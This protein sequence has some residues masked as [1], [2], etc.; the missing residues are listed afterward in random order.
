MRGIGTKLSCLAALAIAQPAAAATELFSETFETAANGG[1]GKFVS[2][3]QVG[4]ASGQAYRDIGFGGVDPARLANR[5]AAFGG[6]NSRFPGTILSTT[7]AGSA[8]ATL[9]TINFDAGYIGGVAANIAGQY[10]MFTAIDGD[11]NSVEADLQP[12]ASGDPSATGRLGG[13]DNVDTVFSRYQ[14][15]FTGR[16]PISLSFTAGGERGDNADVLLDNVLVRAGAVPE[17]STW[18]MML[19]GF[20]VIGGMVRRR[21]MARPAAA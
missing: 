10:L 19:L 13:S 12:A 16:G 20:G 7:I 21:P 5:F 4:I 1:F 6:G 18:A 11:G 8:T 9:Y 3:G 17:A 14:Y 15:Q 2:N